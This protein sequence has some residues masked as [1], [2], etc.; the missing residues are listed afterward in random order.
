M[1]V[2]REM[3][4]VDMADNSLRNEMRKK[5]P[6]GE[7]SLCCMIMLL[8]RFLLILELLLLLTKRSID[9]KVKARGREVVI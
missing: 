5:L 8:I 6:L 9:K 4:K 2:S 3:R 7:P 1:P